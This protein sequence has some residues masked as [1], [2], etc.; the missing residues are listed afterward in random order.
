MG[1]KTKINKIY[2][3]IYVYTLWTDQKNIPFFVVNLG[4]ARIN[5][6]H[7]DFWLSFTKNHA[8]KMILSTHYT[9]SFLT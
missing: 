3:D 6:L 2:W 4:E 1:E 5:L 9:Q 7:V 8:S